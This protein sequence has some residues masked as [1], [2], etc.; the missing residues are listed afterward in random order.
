MRPFAIILKAR[1]PAW[2]GAAL[3]AAMSLIGA[4]APA[5]AQEPIKIGF[6]VS[7]TGGLASS[8]KAHLL[9]KQIWLEEINAKGGLLGRP[10]K[11]VY[12]D[13]QTNAAT[14]PGIYAKLMDID[15][16]D[17]LMGAATNLIVA[18]MPMIMERKKMV[19]VLL[20]L[21]SNAEFK[22]PRYFQSAPFGPDPKGVLSSAF[23]AVAKSINPTPKTVALVGADAE[24][25]NNVLIGARENAKQAGL[26]IVY[27][28][29]YPPSTV[30]YTPIV[31]AVQATNPDVVLLASYPPDSVGMVR[32]ATEIGLKTQLFGGAMVG[33]Q[34]ASLITQLSEKLNRVVNYH[35]FV[36]SP[37][38]NFPGI[39]EFLKKYQAQAKDAGVDPLGFYQP[40]FAYAAMQV[41]QQAITATGSLNDDKLAAYIH[42]N[43]FNTIVGEIRF[44]D[45][46]EWANARTLMIQFQGVQGQGLEQYLTGHRQV[47][48]YPAEYKEGDLEQPFAK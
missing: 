13:D 4:I 33:M 17:V 41:L 37:K 19:M 34:Y 1:M 32:A 31:R 24:F 23:F 16:V 10:V 21:G 12:Y 44:N 11:L 36:P 26:Q 46:G 39:D 22:Y 9:S 8:G 20:A 30:D 43:S 15:K 3:L 45:L 25:A 47:I 14:V 28:R 6:S 2:A 7:L 18:A 40:P 35:F 29:S 48:V 42:G 27:D 5:P 38:M